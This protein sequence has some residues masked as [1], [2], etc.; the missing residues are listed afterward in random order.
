V[1]CKAFSL[2]YIIQTA[3]KTHLELAMLTVSEQLSQEFETQLCL[4]NIQSQQRRD[5]HK[6][7]RFYLDFCAKF[8]LDAMLTRSFAEFDDK[9]KSKGQ[10]DRQRQQARQAIGLYY[11]LAGVIKPSAPPAKNSAARSAGKTQP[12]KP[13][14]TPDHDSPNQADL[15]P[16]LAVSKTLKLTGAN[17][18]AVYDQLQ[19]SIKVRHYSNKTWQANRYGCNSFKPSLKARM[20]ACWAWTT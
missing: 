18:E 1:N 20:P 8:G 2:L 15:P 10:T 16:V 11:R 17:W 7:L 14:N 19:A 9:L 13:T 12:L 6:W 4:R 3:S 5:Y